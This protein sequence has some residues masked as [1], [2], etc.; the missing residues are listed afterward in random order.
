MFAEKKLGESE[1]KGAA[2]LPSILYNLGRVVSYT[3]VG[4]LLGLIGWLIGGSS[5]IEVPILLQGILKLIAGTLMIVMGINMLGIFPWLRRLNIQMPKFIGLSN[6][7]TLFLAD[8][9]FIQSIRVTL[10]FALFTGPISYVLCFLLAWLINELHPKLRTIFTLI[11][12]APSMANVYT[13]WK[14][15]FSGDSYG[16]LNSFLLDLGLINAPIQ[17]LTDGSYVLGVTMTYTAVITGVGMPLLYRFGATKAR[18][19]LLVLMGIS[20]ALGGS[21]AVVGL[22]ALGGVPDSIS[23]ALTITAVVLWALMP[24]SLRLTERFYRRGGV[25]HER[26][27][28]VEA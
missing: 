16:Y 13:V 3:L 12:Y 4:F 19:T 9:V 8:K 25:D 18:L 17:W 11:F 10:V 6:Y 27:P 5:G 23:I 21:A 20:A 24:F 14:L 7:T 22:A 2:F 1:K 15:I 28:I 26:H